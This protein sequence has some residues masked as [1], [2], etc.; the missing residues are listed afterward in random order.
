MFAPAPLRPKLS[1]P[2]ADPCLKCFQ[3]GGH[4][5]DGVGITTCDPIM[6]AMGVWA[7]NRE[8][9]RTAEMEELKARARRLLAE[10]QSP[11]S[12]PS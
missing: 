6:A 1:T 2:P 11:G 5:V 7:R 10:K 8:L 3:T 12:S 9:A 4:Q